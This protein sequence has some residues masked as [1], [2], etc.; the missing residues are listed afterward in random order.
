MNLPTV[1]PETGRVLREEMEYKAKANMCGSCNY[2][3]VGH[4]ETMCIVFVNQL[5]AIPIS[6]TGICKL[7]TAGVNPCA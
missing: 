2:C 5:G 1:K 3:R 4:Q 6:P 7:W